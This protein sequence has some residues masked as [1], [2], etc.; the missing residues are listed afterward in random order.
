MLSPPASCSHIPQKGGCAPPTRVGGLQ[1]FSLPSPLRGARSARYQSGDES[2]HSKGVALHQFVQTPVQAFSLPGDAQPFAP[3]GSGASPASTGFT[4]N[5]KF[6]HQ[7]PSAQAQ[8]QRFR[9][10][11]LSFFLRPDLPPRRD[12]TRFMQVTTIRNSNYND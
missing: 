10:S 2:P 11:P 7:P 3:A 12:L 8:N 4:G 5:S 1:A 9:Y 6:A